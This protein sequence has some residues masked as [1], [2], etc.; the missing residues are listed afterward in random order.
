MCFL[1]ARATLEIKIFSFV[2]VALVLLL[3]SIKAASLHMFVCLQY[4][5]ICTGICFAHISLGGWGGGGPHGY[6]WLNRQYNFNF[7]TMK[8]VSFS[9]KSLE[10]GE[11]FGSARRTW[12]MLT[13]F[14][15]NLKILWCQR[16]FYNKPTE[17]CKIT[18][19]TYPLQDAL[20]PSSNSSWRKT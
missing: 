17:F 9:S 19:H 2:E 1:K 18:C 7:S 8:R 20:Q 15:F 10:K 5:W 3:C 11:N 14:H 12:V 6:I 16:F 4:A 13:T